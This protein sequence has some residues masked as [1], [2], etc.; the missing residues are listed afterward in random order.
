[1]CTKI[2]IFFPKWTFHKVT[3]TYSQCWY[4][5]DPTTS[6]CESLVTSFSSSH[7]IYFSFLSLLAYRIQK[8]NC[9]FDFEWNLP[10]CWAS[11]SFSIRKSACILNNSKPC[12][13][14]PD[15]TLLTCFNF[16]IIHF[17]V[18]CE[19]VFYPISCLPLSFQSIKWYKEYKQK[20]KHFLKLL[21]NYPETPHILVLQVEG[22][23][24]SS[25]SY[26]GRYA[27][28]KFWSLFWSFLFAVIRSYER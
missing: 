15:T 10:S 9:W 23:I 20:W 7:L 26:L 5:S 3:Q 1:M 16:L 12:L 18:G 27:L 19:W 25:Y 4:L 17:I 14:I 2:F 21:R 22:L 6:N 11:E 8:E 13:K 24:I 28:N